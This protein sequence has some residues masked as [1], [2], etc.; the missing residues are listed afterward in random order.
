MRTDDSFSNEIQ[1]EHHLSHSILLNISNFGIV[2]HIPLDYMHLICIG[3]VK[4]LIKLW[5]SGPLKT[6][7]LT[8]RKIKNVS[9][10]LLNIRHFIPKEFAR[11]PREVE[12]IVQ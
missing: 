6:R 10:S 1:E 5:I 12:D 3:V 9:K 7:C 2:S 4:K 8:S 11:R